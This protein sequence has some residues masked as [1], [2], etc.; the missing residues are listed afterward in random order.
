M[1]DSR[2]K[3][4]RKKGYKPFWESE[5]EEELEPPAPVEE[6]EE[7][8]KERYKLVKGLMNHGLGRVLNKKK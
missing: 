3:L 7:K 5:E 6:P 4:F 8:D 2:K 1:E